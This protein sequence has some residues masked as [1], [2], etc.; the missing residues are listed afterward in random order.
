MHRA[1]LLP[2]LVGATFLS[3][4]LPAQAGKT[5]PSTD[6]SAFFQPPQRPALPA[7]KDKAWIVNAVDAFILARLEAEGLAPSLEADKLRL[8]RRVTFDLTG[9]PPTIAEQDAFLH[10]TSANSYR[11]VVDRLLASPRYGELAAA[12]HSA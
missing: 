10:D 9:L 5:K 12:Q 7:V 4:A 11:R 6:S 2:M 8:L 1:C 3:I